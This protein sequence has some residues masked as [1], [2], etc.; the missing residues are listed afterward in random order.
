LSWPS[1]ETRGHTFAIARRA[2]VERVLGV[3][4]RAE[5]IARARFVQEL[6]HIDNAN[7]LEADLE[8]AHLTTFVNFDAVFCS[9]LLYHLPEPW[10]LIAQLPHVAPQLFV[11]THYAEENPGNL[12]L[13]D[14]KGC[15]YVEGGKDEPLSGVSPK[16]FW[17]TL[18][19]LR[20]VLTN[21]GFDSIRVLRD[22]PKHSHGPAVTLTAKMQSVAT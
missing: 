13:N 1:T 6:L 8:K 15:E 18:D 4:V 10:K 20:K 19:S 22:D 2:G 5:N 21:A 7:F 16:S 17:L 11:W 12:T 14:L 9:G 3:E